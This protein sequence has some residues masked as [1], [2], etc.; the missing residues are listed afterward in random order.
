MSGTIGLSFTDD[1]W[2]TSLW[3]GGLRTSMRRG[4]ENRLKDRAE[5]RRTKSRT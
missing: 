1:R 5:G 4:R 2:C 3:R